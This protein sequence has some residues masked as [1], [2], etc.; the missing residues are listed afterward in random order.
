MNLIATLILV[1]ALGIPPVW[2]Q[3]MYDSTDRQ[4]DR[5]DAERYYVA[6]GRQIGRTDGQKYWVISLT[7]QRQLRR[8]VDPPQPLSLH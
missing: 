6:S 2:A 7:K 1:A 5:A 4:I 3:R 8:F